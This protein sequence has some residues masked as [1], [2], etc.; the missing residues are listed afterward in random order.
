M[1][2]LAAP[3]LLAT[4]VAGHGHVSNIVING[5]SYEGWD[6]NTFPYQSDPP[7]VVAWGTP[8][9]ANGFITPGQWSNIIVP[10]PPRLFLPL[11]PMIS[12]LAMIETL[13]DRNRQLRN[14]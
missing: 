8:N 2:R 10:Q 6:I 1:F 3:L 14:V 9:T 4:L 12:R 5:V 11:P 7:T 13:T